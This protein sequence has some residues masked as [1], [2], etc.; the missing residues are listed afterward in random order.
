MVDNIDTSLKDIP[1]EQ[2]GLSVL[3]NNSLRRAGLVSVYDVCQ[4]IKADDLSI[5]QNIG[6]KSKTEI[7]EKTNHFLMSYDSS[8]LVTNQV[9]PDLR[10]DPSTFNNNEGFNLPDITSI[11]NLQLA[12]LKYRL[13]LET[14]SSLE[15]VGV[16][17]I[18]DFH[19]LVNRYIKFIGSGSDLISTVI[20]ELVMQVSN[21][22]KAGRLSGSCFV[23]ST[24]LSDLI[25]WQPTND[26]DS[27]HKL[28][29]LK[30]ILEENSLTDEMNRFAS[31]L[32]ERQREVFLDYSLHDMTLEAIGAKQGVTRE[33][34]RQIVSDAAIKLRR[35]LDS[36]LKAYIST[37][38]EI[39]KA[40]GSSL[41]RDSWK[42]ELIQRQILLDNDRDFA[43]FDFLIALL[44]NK[45][46]AQSI[47]GVPDNVQLILRSDSSH[48]L[49]VISALG[50]DIRKEFKEI[51]NIIKFTGG[52][53]V[54]EAQQI[55]GCESTK[56]AD[57]LQVIDVLEVAPGWF[58]SIARTDLSKNT[59]LFRAGLM[60]MQACGPL[61]F[62]SFCDGLRRYISRRYEEIAPQE[63]VKIFIENLD[64]KVDNDIVSYYGNEQ[65][66]M[67]ES[68]SLILHLLSERGPVLNFQEIVEFFIA[69][70]KSFAT[71]TTKIMPRSPIIEK[72]EHSLYK[73]R[74][75]KVSLQ[76]I[77]TA[78]TRQ[79]ENTM[80]P[81]V[82]YG[83]DG[84]VRYRLTLGSWATG[85]VLSIGRSCRPLPDFREGWPV[86]VNDEPVGTARRDDYLIWGLTA[87][88][89][90]LGSK[91]GDRVELAFDIFNGPRINLRIVGETND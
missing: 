63:V 85:G 1:L 88:L 14:V 51:K 9:S 41:S 70:D 69:N 68:E 36:S 35:A 67:P 76:D 32:T 83:S 87:A 55:L 18:Q 62:D 56:T 22:V 54:E 46:T 73:L 79:E 19:A 7:I 43:S 65:T 81:E 23:E 34:I 59:P 78:K 30:L 38:F 40:M 17:K 53:S 90:R 86:Y 20:S 37:S 4:R 21:L 50:G 31:A 5:I 3:A 25:C 61:P 82:M 6:A 28:Q 75:S 91:L 27:N 2:L 52:I 84:I 26:N 64:F 33:R 12:T 74:G 49:F 77:E 71:A 57:L 10:T 45:I 13:G 72:V 60:M 42:G 24:T 80:N 29:L 11:A 89:N 16:E 66:E 58:T 39:A 8:P 15:G 47:F 48:P 44:K